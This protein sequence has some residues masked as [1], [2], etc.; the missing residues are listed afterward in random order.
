M[1]A[2]QMPVT[3]APGQHPHE[4][5]GRLINCYAEKLDGAAGTQVVVHRV[6]GL[7]GFATSNQSGF[8][9]ALQVG[10]TLYSAWSGKVYKCSSTGGALAALT[11]SLTG[12][13]RVFMARNNAATPDLVV[14]SPGD[15]AFVASTTA[16]SSYP[17][18]D[19]GSPNAVCEHKSFFIFTR[20]NGTIIAT[21][22]NSTAI[23]TLDTATAEYKPDT[24]Y[25]P[26]SYKDNLLIWGSESVEFWGGLNDTG[27]PFSF[28]SAMDIG[29]V[30][31]YAVG[32]DT[33]GFDAGIYFVASDFRFSRIVGYGREVIPH[34]DLERLISLV[35][36]KTTI[37]VD[38]YVERGRPVVVISSP[39]WTWEYSVTSGTFNERASY[40]GTRWRGLQPFKAFDRWH[41]GD[42]ESGNL[43]R[44]D[45]QEQMEAGQPLVFITE[46]G[47]MGNFPKPLRADRVELYM[48]RGVGIAT[49]LDPQQTD[50]QIECQFSP[51]GGLSW[52]DPRRAKLGRQQIASGR[53]A[54]NML[55]MAHPQGAR[56]R[57]IIADPV[58]VGLMGGDLR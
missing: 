25:R 36:D 29:I 14:V 55:G 43:L 26:M 49:G 4:S 11:G 7:M 17:D 6:P 3:T 46:P 40:L 50:P 5:G 41:C 21:G 13:A 2:F 56:L 27:F 58:P 19:V 30:G 18:A 51:D 39:T 31:P 42:T 10:S 16:V 32:G 54:F 12:T 24:A 53:V 38:C 20:G 35:E 48:T 57:F 47:P 23:N 1:T 15:G 37:T 52:K 44:L 34:A 28:I 9:G 33:D 45:F 22:P 8:R